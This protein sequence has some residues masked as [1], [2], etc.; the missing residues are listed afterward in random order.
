MMWPDG[1]ST[2]G[3]DFWHAVEF[4]RNGRFLQDPFTGL[5]EQ[6]VSMLLRSF[7]VL[8]LSRPFHQ[9]VQLTFAPSSRAVSGPFRRVKL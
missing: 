3:V 7:F 8:K 1:V 6:F 2:F 5:S 9:S 4:S